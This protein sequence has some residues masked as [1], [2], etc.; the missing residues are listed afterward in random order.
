MV[1]TLGQ[2]FRLNLAVDV[3]VTAILG[4]TL[5]LWFG[6]LYFLVGIWK[7]SDVLEDNVKHTRFQEF[8]KLLSNLAE[9]ADRAVKDAK[10]LLDL[11]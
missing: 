2:V 10:A 5:V 7:L 8:V 1:Q 6:G 9:I 11:A 4:W 3:H